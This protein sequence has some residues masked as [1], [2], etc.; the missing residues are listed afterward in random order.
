M[1]GVQIQI[2][3]SGI[4]AF[5][6]MQCYAYIHVHDEDAL[7]TRYLTRVPSPRLSTFLEV[8]AMHFLSFVRSEFTPYMGLYKAPACLRYLM[9]CPHCA[10]CVK[11]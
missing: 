5:R 7:T 1:I 2:D 11:R 9:E 4:C 8:C 6:D 3:I 10:L